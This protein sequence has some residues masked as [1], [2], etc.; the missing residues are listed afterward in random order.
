VAVEGISVYPPRWAG[1]R[2]R[3]VWREPDGR[4]G[5]CQAVTGGR[6][7]ARLG[8]VAERLTADA[9][10]MLRSG[11]DLIG[12]YLSADRLPPGR[13]WSRRHT[14]T[15]RYLR[16]VRGPGDRY[17]PMTIAAVYRVPTERTG[18]ASALVSVTRTVGGAVGLAVIST[19]V[20]SRISHGAAAVTRSATRSAADSASR[21]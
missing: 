1:D 6:L 13:Q 14:E 7:A 15:Q 2:W 5:H 4:R 12:H 8:P 16:P 21:S 19:V 20:T 9:P 17:I 18:V 3:A 10:N 11:T